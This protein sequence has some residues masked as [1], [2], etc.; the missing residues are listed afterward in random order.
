MFLCHSLASRL[1][2]PDYFV[3]LGQM[4]VPDCLRGSAKSGETL[5]FVHLSCLPSHDP[6]LQ[7]DL[8]I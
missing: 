6:H 2:L 3:S 8:I 1:E 5:G 7:H 4:G